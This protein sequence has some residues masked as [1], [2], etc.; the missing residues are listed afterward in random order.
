MNKSPSELI[1]VGELQVGMYVELGVGWMAHPFATGSFRI[2]SQ[3]QIE[4]IQSLGLRQVRHFPERDDLIE[5]TGPWGGPVAAS[6]EP[7]PPL[8][9][10]RAPAPVAATLAERVSAQRRVLLQCERHFEEA[11]A[12]YKSSSSRPRPSRR[13]PGCAANGRW[14]SSWRA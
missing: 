12:V 5:F 2:V 3:R 8:A 9:A 11:A 7:E 1:D 4:I 13:R 10:P 6:A 14:P